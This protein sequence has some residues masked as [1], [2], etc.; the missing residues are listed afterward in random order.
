MQ[1]ISYCQ[2]LNDLINIYCN[3]LQMNDVH[4]F[5]FLKHCTM[6]NVQMLGNFKADKTYHCQHSAEF[7]LFLSFFEIY[8]YYYYYYYYHHH[9]YY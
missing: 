3:I 8:Y 6:S 1:S 9:H 4:L 7:N 2:I 5:V